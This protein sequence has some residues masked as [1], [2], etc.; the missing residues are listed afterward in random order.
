MGGNIK[1][2]PKVIADVK[3]IKPDVMLMNGAFGLKEIATR[4][5]KSGIPTICIASRETVTSVQPGNV[6]LYQL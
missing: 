3:R 6:G 4:L 1:N 5:K 2:I